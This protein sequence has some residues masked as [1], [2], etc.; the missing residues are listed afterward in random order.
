MLM[1]HA[2]AETNGVMGAVDDAGFTVNEDLADV[3]PI[4]SVRDPHGGRFPRAVF[5]DDSVN[6]PRTN[7][8]VDAIVREDVSEALCYVA[9]LEH[10]FSGLALAALNS[11]S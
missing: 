3:R 6:R 4:K 11:P 1:D 9:E 8:N 7:K 10:V 5:A 2:D